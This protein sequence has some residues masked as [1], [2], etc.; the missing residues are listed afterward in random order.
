MVRYSFLVQLSHLLLHAG[1]I[2]ALSLITRPA[3]AST[4]GGSSDQSV[5]V[6][7]FTINLNLFV[8]S[9]TLFDGSVA[10][11]GSH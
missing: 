11:R 1:F 10:P 5:A 6:F 7:K 2:P 4:F 3:L 9:I 8:A